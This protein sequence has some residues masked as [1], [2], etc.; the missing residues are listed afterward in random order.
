M[1]SRTS[2]AVLVVALLSAPD[3]VA[4]SAPRRP[5]TQSIAGKWKACLD[6]E[7]RTACWTYEFKVNGDT[8]T[9]TDTGTDGVVTLLAQGRIQGERVSFKTG[10]GCTEV[11]MRACMA[12]VS[13]GTYRGGD[14]WRLY[15]DD[16]DNNRQ[17]G[18]TMT[19]VKK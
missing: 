12:V 1:I 3:L 5:T 18:V 4:Q 19:R 7:G 14:E 6:A 15:M 17:Y 9:G 2:A 11:T 16:T 13:T 10:H 8:L